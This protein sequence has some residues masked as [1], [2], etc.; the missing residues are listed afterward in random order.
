MELYF[1]IVKNGLR[2]EKDF[3][4]ELKR[5]HGHNKINQNEFGRFGV[6]HWTVPFFFGIL[7]QIISKGM[8]H[9]VDHFSLQPVIGPA[10]AA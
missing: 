8:E 1:Y 2:I 9:L 10:P 6:Y 7:S 5:N 3:F 4:T